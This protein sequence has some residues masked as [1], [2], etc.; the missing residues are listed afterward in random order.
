[1]LVSTLIKP[2]DKAV[3]LPIALKWIGEKASAIASS[4]P[5][6]QSNCSLY[7]LYQ[8][9]RRRERRLPVLL[10]QFNE[11]IKG[12]KATNGSDIQILI[13]KFKQT[14]DAVM[15]PAQELQLSNVPG[16]NASERHL[17]FTK[18]LRS[19][20]QLVHVNLSRNEAIAGVTLEVFSHLNGTLKCLNLSNCVGFGSSLQP[21]RR[22]LKLKYLSLPGCLSLEG[23]LEPLKGLQDLAVLDV[24]A[25]SVLSMARVSGNF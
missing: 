24:E 18:T 12:M 3:N 8:H 13:K 21:L 14:F 11:D 5:A 2:A 19:C 15:A 6:A 16:P 9:A 4:D 7:W 23:S 17:F 25:A 20:T 10:E 22:F 1:M